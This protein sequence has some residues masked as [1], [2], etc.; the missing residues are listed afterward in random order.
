MQRQ[1]KFLTLQRRIATERREVEKLQTFTADSTLDDYFQTPVSEATCPV[2]S[3]GELNQL[4]QS[5]VKLGTGADTKHSKPLQIIDFMWT[6]PVPQFSTYSFGTESGLELR[7]AKKKTLYK[8]SLE[9]WGYANICILLELIRRKDLDPTG[10]TSY[11][12]YT[13][14]IFRLASKYVWYSVVL[15]DKEYREQQ[16]IEKFP[17]GTHRQDLR[18]FQLILKR[19]HPT[20]RAFQDVYP[21][22]QRQQ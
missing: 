20:I 15:Y 9:E 8:I 3:Q 1:R 16:A 19:D 18:E 17:W 7:V 14:E 6:D 5:P 2:P 4:F 11:L 13:S 22:T 10:I 12:K 21:S